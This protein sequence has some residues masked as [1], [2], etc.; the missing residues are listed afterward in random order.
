MI[1]IKNNGRSFIK[2]AFLLSAAGIIC[3]LIGAFYRVPLSNILGTEGMGVYQMAYP[4]YS[5]LITF[6]TAGV[7][8]AVSSMVSEKL[9]DNDEQGAADIFRVSKISLLAVGVLCSLILFFGADMT[10]AI[11]DRGAGQEGICILPQLLIP[12]LA[13]VGDSAVQL[14]GDRA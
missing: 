13:A 3:K 1:T 11:V 10:V 14:P 12:D 9:A 4:V 5:A 8:V 7:P 6:S 2:G